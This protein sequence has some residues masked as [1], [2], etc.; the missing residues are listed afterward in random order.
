MEPTILI[1]M[2]IY[3]KFKMLT[4]MIKIFF[5]LYSTQKMTIMK[6]LSIY[7]LL[8]IEIGKFY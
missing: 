2:Q 4:L 1:K 7:N 8:S 6:I 3:Q 5:L